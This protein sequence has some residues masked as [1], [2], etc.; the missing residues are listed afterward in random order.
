MPGGLVDLTNFNPWKDESERSWRRH[1]ARQQAMQGAF[2]ALQQNLQRGIDRR[3]RVAEQ[4]R[5]MRDRE[6]A[7]INEKTDKIFQDH[8]GQKVNDVQLQQTGQMIKQEY[9]DA[10][11]TYQD[12]DKGDEAR[13]AF[14]QAKQKALTSARTISKAL[15]NVDAQISTFQDAI[16]DGGISDATDPAVRSFIGDLMDPNTPPDQ[17]R[18]E[19]DP[20]TGQLKYVGQTSDGQDVSIF[21]DDLANGDI[22][23]SPI[24]KADMPK[25]IMNLTKGVT[26]ITKQ[27]KYDWGVAEVTD[28]DTIGLALDSRID[29]LIKDDKAFKQIGAELGYDYNAFQAIMSG[30]GFT[31]EDGR[32]IT[33]EAEL[34][35]AVKEE[36]LQQIESVTPHLNRE[37][38]RTTQQTQKEATVAERTAKTQQVF[39]T[40]G[41]GDPNYFNTVF[42]GKS[43]NLQGVKSN[44]REAEVKGGVLRIKGVTGSGKSAKIVK[45]DFNLADP[46]SMAQLAVLLGVD[47]TDAFNQ[48]RIIKL[49]QVQQ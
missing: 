35:G 5:A 44:F 14:E 32:E 17:Y 40:I 48:A 3:N 12:S 16:K 23:Y 31:D 24:P 43:V 47:P 22:A 25:I 28:W 37:L 15:D 41:S 10:V 49:S 4:N 8:Q 1:N 34:R 29:E 38:Q 27:E 2:Q 20:E 45:Q 30:E 9:Y 26:D 33:N 7:L 11:K 18:I 13:A 36:L 46:D 21:L 42:T 6:Y 39:D 19:T